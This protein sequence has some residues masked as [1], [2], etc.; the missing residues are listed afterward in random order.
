MAA[1]RFDIDKFDGIANFNLWQVRMSTVLIHSDL[2][3]VLIE[4][5]LAGIEQSSEIETEALYL[6]KSLAN[7]LVFKRLYTFRMI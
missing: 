1:S 4:K 7:R 5:K 6:T 2:E 3:R